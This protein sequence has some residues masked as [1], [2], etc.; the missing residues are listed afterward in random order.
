MFLP[1]PEYRP[2]VND[3]NGNHTQSLSGVLPRGDGWG[4]VQGLDTAFAS[5]LG[6]ACRGF[7]YTR[8]NDGSIDIF[9]G[10][11][12]KL[13][14]L[15]RTAYTWSDV[16]KGAG[17][18]SSVPN[19]GQWQ[20]AQ[21]G[22]KLIA[23]HAAVVPQVYNI[24][25][26][27]SAF[28]DLA[29]SPP[30]A[31]YMTVVGRFV[32]LTGIVNAPMRIQWSGLD[33]AEEWTPGTE[34]S[35]YTDMADGG[36]T[37]GVAG[38]EFGVLLQEQAVRRLVYVPGAT[39]AFQIEKIAE[40]IGIFAPFSITRAGPN[41]FW[42]ASTG[43]YE[44]GPSGPPAPIGKERVDRTILA[45]MDTGDIR[46]VIGTPD[47]AGTRVL[48]AYKSGSGTSGRFDKLIAYDYMLQRWSPMLSVTGEYI[49]P[50]V[51]P[52]VTLESLPSNLDTLLGSLDDYPVALSLKLAAVNTSHAMAFF[53]GSNIEATLYTSERGLDN[54]QRMYIRG[55]APRT[56]AGT[57][58]GAIA[59]RDDANDS[60]STTS[61][62]TMNTTGGWCPQRIDTRLARAKIRIPSGT[63]WTYAMGVEPNFVPT[64][65]WGS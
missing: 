8:R 9:A 35:N 15:D 49:G 4:P 26:P 5:A 51:Q 47:P 45:D 46:M 11:A 37:K 55:L 25:G 21:F 34:F 20:F 33:N 48:W 10:T 41:I 65:M 60:A 31:A 32:V 13:Y 16:S 28:A 27:G 54:R 52:G 38:G 23:C 43:F 58:Y 18:Y 44:A 19:K 24:D 64:G 22:N 57:V 42:I 53:T 29:G 50:V 17:T 36:P 6:A 3:F 61:E 56:D 40:N 63:S 30:T 1:F 14:K 2:D 12:T 39:P 7:I 62:T 59:Y